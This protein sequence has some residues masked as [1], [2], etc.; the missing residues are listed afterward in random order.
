[1]NG[2]G[3]GENVMTMKSLRDDVPE[4]TDAEMVL[5]HSE[6]R[7]GSFFAVPTTAKASNDCNL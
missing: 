3:L 7:I 2:K 4:P 1:M 6:N 5:S